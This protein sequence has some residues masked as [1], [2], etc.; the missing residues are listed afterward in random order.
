MTIEDMGELTPP[1]AW[2]KMKGGFALNSIIYKLAAIKLAATINN[3]LLFNSNAF[4]LVN[5]LLGKLSS[6]MWLRPQGEHL[7]C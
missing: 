7:P 6:I 2:D 3:A 1:D 4:M 5:A